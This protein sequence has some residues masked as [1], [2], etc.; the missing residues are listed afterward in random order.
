MRAIALPRR[1]FLVVAS[2]PFSLTTALCRRLLGDPAV[3]LDGA[4]LIAQW[5]AA[6]WL[7]A[8]RPRDAETAWWSA[9]YEIHLAGVINSASFAPPP[10]VNAAWLSVRPR[11]VPIPAPGQRCLRAIVQAAYRRPAART[12]IAV[13][14]RKRLLLRA[15]LDPAAPVA[16]V[17]A[18]Q[19]HRL[20]VLLAG[21]TTGVS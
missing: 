16:E 18:E 19:W 3:P 21:G 9:R 6:R 17:T 12:D 8:Q 14:V 1:K 4:E 15:G 20:A 10:R 7:A 5:G 13:A 2:P 11:P